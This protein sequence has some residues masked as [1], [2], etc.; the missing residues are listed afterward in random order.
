MIPSLSLSRAT[1]LVFHRP[2]RAA[3][4]EGA[5]VSTAVP[6]PADHLRP[7]PLYIEEELKKRM[8]EKFGKSG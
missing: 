8:S 2:A 3:P 7:L 6:P 5:N 4:D 1:G